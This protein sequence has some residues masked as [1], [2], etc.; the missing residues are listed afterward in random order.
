MNLLKGTIAAINTKGSLSLVY[1]QFGDVRLT[2][3]VTDT[4]VTAP[5]LKIGNSITVIFKESEVFIGKGIDHQISLQNKLV[6]TI[7]TIAK[8][9]LL[10][11][12]VLDTTVGTITSII[13][14]NAVDQLQLIEG[15]TVTAMRC[16]WTRPSSSWGSFCPNRT[17]PSSRSSPRS[18]YARWQDEG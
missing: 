12:L 6:G 7:T 17:T 3:I 4:P 5:Y 15:E 10:S 14:A 18:G 13:T 2:A 8:G 16:T 9:E 11:K 1:V